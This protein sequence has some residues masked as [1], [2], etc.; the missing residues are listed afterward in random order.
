MWEADFGSPIIGVYLREGDG[1]M[2]MPFTTMDDNSMP[3]HDLQFTK[4]IKLL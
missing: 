3:S 1:L 2:S 4:Q